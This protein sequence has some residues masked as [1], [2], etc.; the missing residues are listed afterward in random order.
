MRREVNQNAA[1]GQ[2]VTWGLLKKRRQIIE[3][4]VIKKKSES[5]RCTTSV[6]SDLPLT[7]TRKESWKEERVGDKWGEEY[8]G[9]ILSLCR[10]EVPSLNYFPLE[11]KTLFFQ[12]TPL[13]ATTLFSRAPDFSLPACQQ[14][15]FIWLI[16]QRFCIYRFVLYAACALL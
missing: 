11:K 3:W 9:E 4:T 13:Y 14:N 2:L 5:R 16:E 7:R 6:S 12:G 8:K 1:R 15:P 10:H